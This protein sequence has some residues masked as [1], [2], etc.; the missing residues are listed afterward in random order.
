LSIC[1]KQ[2]SISDAIL[3]WHSRQ[4]AAPTPVLDS[5]TTSEATQVVVKINDNLKLS[6]VP[7][8]LAPNARKTD[9]GVRVV[10]EK[11][12]TAK[13][14]AVVPAK[15]TTTVA[16]TPQTWHRLM[17]RENLQEV[18]SVITALRAEIEAASTRKQ[19]ESIADEA[20]LFKNCLNLSQL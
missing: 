13:T 7:A 14:A 19:R 6:V 17:Q 2:E 5:T 4:L 3:M 9:C 8:A 11:I 18:Q 1:E 12:S 10:F 20:T 16:I 15:K